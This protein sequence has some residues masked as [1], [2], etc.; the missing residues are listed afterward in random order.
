MTLV[1][2]A[3]P[4]LAYFLGEPAGRSVREILRAVGA[5][6]EVAWASVV[7]LAE[8]DYTLRRRTPRKVGALLEWLLATGVKPASA[9]DTWKEAARIKAE[10]SIGI[11][12][13]FALATALEKRATLVVGDDPDFDN[14]DALG[15]DLKRV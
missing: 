1:F 7:N 10:H 11:A 9:D 12:D 4:L 6:G 2:D 8:V 15:V 14:A 13:A 3:Q 5:G